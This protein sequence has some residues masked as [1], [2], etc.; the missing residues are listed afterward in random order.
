MSEF[1]DIHTEPT[2]QQMLELKLLGVMTAKSQQKLKG[3]KSFNNAKL[4]MIKEVD[5]Y[6]CTEDKQEP[7]YWAHR[8]TGRIARK[9]LQKKGYQKWSMRIAESFWMQNEKTG[10]NDGCRATYKFEWTDESVILAWK[11]I[12]VTERVREDFEKG[13]KQIKAKRKSAP[14][15]I[16]ISNG[17]EGHTWIYRRTQ[18]AWLGSIGAET[19]PSTRPFDENMQHMASQLSE[20]AYGE[21]D[22]LIQDV[23]IFCDTS[24]LLHFRSLGMTAMRA[25]PSSLYL[26]EHA[27]VE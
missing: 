10:I 19:E 5:G 8:F 12:H 17:E 18:A 15:G 21:V 25:L 27:G 4:F 11:N 23:K 2:V 22:Q 7:Y 20:V 3:S 13:Q 24:K 26:Y 9:G 1:L 14:S 6:I 16:V